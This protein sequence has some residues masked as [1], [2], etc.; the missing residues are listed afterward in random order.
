[1]EI[2]NYSSLIELSATLNIAFV[3][4]EYVKSY[5]DLVCNN[6]FKINSHITEQFNKRRDSIVNKKTIDNI[7]PIIVNGKSTL[8]KIEEI[9]RAREKYLSD[10]E[11]EREK[12]SE[13]V[14]DIC[15]TRSM[16]SL[17]LTAFF[18]S[19]FALLVSSFQCQVPEMIR[20]V[21]SIYTIFIAIFMITGWVVG[22]KHKFKYL[23]YT[24]LRHAIIY[25]ISLFILSCVTG[26]IISDNNHVIY[27]FS[28]SLWNIILIVSIALMYFNFIIFILKI[29][30]R[31]KKII[32]T[33]DNKCKE[34][35]DRNK[36]IQDGIDGLLK[37]NQLSEELDLGFIED[38]DFSSKA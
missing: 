2:S 8:L 6:I 17:S 11:E 29:W 20:I 30:H 14:S 24:Q 15:A 32:S 35:E 22:E 21:W 7:E 25:S 28:Y 33:I 23:D 36:A 10:I 5:T 26:Y 1:M 18:F 34:F 12:I 3:A 31:G 9:K 38:N 4:V 37:V 13:S 19:F 27:Y 16:S